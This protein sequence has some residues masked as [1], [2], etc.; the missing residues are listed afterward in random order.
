[1]PAECP[2]RLHLH[3]PCTQLR[4][5][6]SAAQLTLTLPQPA[7]LLL[8][9]AAGGSKDVR[10]S[11]YERTELAR[12]LAE[13]DVVELPGGERRRACHFVDPTGTIS[14]PIFSLTSPISP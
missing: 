9:G 2:S 11:A 6:S 8:L 5:A 3:C 7:L 1:M 10:L 14:D 13:M 12:R 4:R